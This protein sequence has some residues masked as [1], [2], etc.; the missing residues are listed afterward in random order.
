MVKSFQLGVEDTLSQAEIYSH[1]S[2]GVHLMFEYKGYT[3]GV[4]MMFRAMSL[5]VREVMGSIERAPY[6]N[7]IFQFL[8]PSL[9]FSSKRCQGRNTKIRQATNHLP[10]GGGP[11]MKITRRYPVR[12]NRT[13]PNRIFMMIGIRR[14]FPLLLLYPSWRVW[15]PHPAQ[16]PLPVRHSCGSPLCLSPPQ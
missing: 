8:S 1:S 10:D 3:P 16:L 15:L 2:S 13:I 6:F 5:V 4:S 7:E 9:S 12:E 14:V 11:P